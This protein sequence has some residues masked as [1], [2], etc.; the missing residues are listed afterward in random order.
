MSFATAKKSLSA[1]KGHLNSSMKSF[2]T[3]VK[4]KPH[5]PAAAVS[6]MYLRLQNRIDAAFSALDKTTLL[7]GDDE[8]MLSEQVNVDVEKENIDA[9]HEELLKINFEVTELYA[10]VQESFDEPSSQHALLPTRT[11]EKPIVKL[12]A[13]DPPSWNGIK[14]EFYTWKRKFVHIMEEAKILDE[15]TQLCYLQNPKTLPSEYRPL[16]SDCSSIGEVWSRLEERVPKSTIQFEIISQFRKVKPLSSKRTPL[17]L[18]EFANE[19]SLFCRRMSDLG[20]HKDNYSCI[21]MQD[22]YERLDRNTALRFR[23]N[24]RLKNEI[25]VTAVEDLESLSSFIRSEATTL[26]LSEGSTLKEYHNPQK[27]IFA[28]QT[29]LD[30]TPE[31]SKNDPSEVRCSLGCEK[32]ID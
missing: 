21:I 24:I 4:I 25:G 5:P 28:A 31:K 15:L 9:Y 7:L 11:L 14:A 18:R 26:E 10:M 13:L 12:T 19:I 32:I 16:I 8:L 23:N 6:K 30:V 3:L 17:V 22:V 29:D 2:T 20:F 1:Y 27:K